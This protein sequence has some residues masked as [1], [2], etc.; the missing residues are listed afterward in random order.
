MLRSC[1]TCQRQFRDLRTLLEHPCLRT[2]VGASAHCDICDKPWP[3]KRSL[4]GHIQHRHH[5]ID[6]APL[7]KRLCDKCHRVVKAVYW[8]GHQRFHER[9]ALGI[10]RLLNCLVEFTHSCSYISNTKGNVQ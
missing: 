1:D 2:T 10:G 6:I 9:K 5:Q 4:F 7:G 3:I 8:A